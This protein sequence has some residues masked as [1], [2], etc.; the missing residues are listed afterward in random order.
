MPVDHDP[1]PVP[2][3]P[4]V[5]SAILWLPPWDLATFPGDITESGFA[6]ITPDRLRVW[7]AAVET[8]AP[9][10]EAPPPPLM[11]CELGIDVERRAY[12]IRVGRRTLWV[13]IDAAGAVLEIGRRASAG[14]GG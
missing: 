3:G 4:R 10:P 8:R 6:G 1:G 9:F 12:A 14:G 7:G 13:N 5:T 11:G 2:E